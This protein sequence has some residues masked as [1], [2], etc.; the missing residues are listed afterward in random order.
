MC[1]N[2]ND[3]IKALLLLLVSLCVTSCTVYTE[4]QSE[5]LSQAVYLADDSFEAGRFDVTDFAI[6]QAV[7]IV[8]VP[9]TRQKVEVITSPSENT[10][11]NIKDKSPIATPPYDGKRVILVPERFKNQEVI[12]VNSHEYQKLLDDKK[13]FTQLQGDY[14]VL[15][16]LK[17][18]VDEELSKQEK[19]NNELI[20]KINKLKED[21]A[22]KTAHILKLY[23]AI[24]SLVLSIAAGVYLRIKGI[25]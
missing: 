11:P 2:N 23:I 7:R 12:V 17:S 9:K 10:K 25:L 6:D 5:A 18:N 24:G 22:K 3:M 15:Q 20:I 14:K 13:T 21:V 19:Y 4:K 16:G 8:K 1:I